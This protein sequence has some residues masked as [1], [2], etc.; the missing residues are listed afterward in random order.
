MKLSKPTNRWMF[1]RSIC[2]IS[3]KYRSLRITDGIMPIRAQNVSHIKE[4][5]LLVNLYNFFFYFERIPL[6]PNSIFHLS[7]KRQFG[8]HQFCCF[9]SISFYQF[10]SCIFC[11]LIFNENIHWKETY[12]NNGTE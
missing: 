5:W 11:L 2:G 8:E 7:T 3:E 9:L 6:S 10:C 4:V 1:E 12:I